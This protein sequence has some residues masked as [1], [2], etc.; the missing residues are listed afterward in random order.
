[1]KKIAI[2]VDEGE[3]CISAFGKVRL[4]SND[5]L[6]VYAETILPTNGK[7]KSECDIKDP[8]IKKDLLEID[9]IVKSSKRFLKNYSKK[10]TPI[11]W[12]KA[13]KETPIIK[14]N[15]VKLCMVS[16]GY[17]RKYLR[18]KVELSGIT[19][20]SAKKEDKWDYTISCSPVDIVKA[21]NAIAALLPIKD[22]RFSI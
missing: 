8:E 2:T 22:Q 5:L 17:F 4:V 15:L 20:S 16:N 13:I 10:S 11:K 9:E 14:G 7:L 21:K 19:K 6:K 12:E 1:M 18:K 3:Y